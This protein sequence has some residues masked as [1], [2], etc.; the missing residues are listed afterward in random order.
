[1]GNYNECSVRVWAFLISEKKKLDANFSRLH[2]NMLSFNF[3]LRKPV[4]R[5]SKWNW[6]II[7]LK[8]ASNLKREFIAAVILNYGIEKKAQNLCLISR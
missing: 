3:Q 6:N 4:Q 2:Q 1:M 5:I 8:L 7:G